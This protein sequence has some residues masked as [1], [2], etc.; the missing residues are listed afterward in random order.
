MSQKSKIL[1]C[2][3]DLSNRE[4]MSFTLRFVDVCEPDL[5]VQENF[6]TFQETEETTGQS[7]FVVI[8]KLLEDS[9]L[10]FK[11][12]RGQSYDNGSNIRG[13]NTGVQA[14]IC[15]ENPRAFFMPR[16]CH[17][18]NLSHWRFCN[19]LHRS[20]FIFWYYTAHLHFIFFICRKMENFKRQCT[21]IYCQTTLQHTLGMPD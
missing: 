1:D 7:L 13:I 20:C 4:K 21:H 15:Q 9:K 12:C 3:P 18:L 5:I 11:N 19:F 14:R 6:I 2:T 10:D 8:K 16:G 17:S